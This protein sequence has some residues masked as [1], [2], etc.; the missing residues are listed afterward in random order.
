MILSEGVTTERAGREKI[1]GTVPVFLVLMSIQRYMAIVHPLSRWKKG[2]C[3]TCVV[4]CAWVVSILAALPDT[5]HAVTYPDSGVCTYSSITA[6]VAIKYEYIIV[7]VCAFL[8]M[9]FCY[10]RILQTI[11]KSPTNRR[12]R[13]TGLAFFL[14]ATFFICWA[15]F[16]I[17]SFLETLTQQQTWFPS[18]VLKYIY[19][20]YICKLLSLIQCCLN[21]MIYGLFGLIFRKT[22]LEI[23]RRRATSNSG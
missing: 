17:M 8:V 11:F 19:A 5:V 21:P 9:A 23:F 15:P 2:R 14:V 6:L 7:F 4:I 10:I 20:I 3:F 16:T 13:T 18:Q 22:V 1:S 12:H